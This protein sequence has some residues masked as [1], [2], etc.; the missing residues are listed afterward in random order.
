MKISTA[1][2]FSLALAGPA[3]A[4]PMA[5][6]VDIC[7]DPLTTGPEKLDLLPANQWQQV[8]DPE[9]APLIDLA[10][11]QIIGFTQGMPNLEERFAAAP[12]LADNFANMARAGQVTLWTRDDAILAVS[13][14]QTP[15]G[16]EHLACYFA[17]PPTD[18]LSTF[19]QR[20]GGPENLPELELIATRFDET[21]VRFNPDITYQ[22]YSAWTRLTSDPART[23]LTDSYRLE[24]VQ[25][26]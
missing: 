26:P 16:G 2:A 24:R 7:S 5:D 14:A 9:S 1:L 25:Q 3:L 23:D 22:M 20:Y 17:S 6:A 11:A 15:D 21:A 19:Q 12:V 4:G 8:S 10:T 18:D 13:F